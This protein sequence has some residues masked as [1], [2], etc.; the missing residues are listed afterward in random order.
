MGAEYEKNNAYGDVPGLRM[1]ESQPKALESL[2]DVPIY[3][4]AEQIDKIELVAKPED[5]PEEFKVEN[6][7]KFV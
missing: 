6:L 3:K 1:A 7:F 2:K 4:Y 5:F